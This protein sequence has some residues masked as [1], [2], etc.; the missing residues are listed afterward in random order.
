MVW[1]F[2]RRCICAAALVGSVYIP[3]GKDHFEKNKNTKSELFFFSFALNAWI[4][5]NIP[6]AK[7]IRVNLICK[8][9]L[10]T[11]GLLM[12]VPPD[13]QN[14]RD[15][16]RKTI[17]VRVVHMKWDTNH[18]FL[19]VLDLDDQMFPVMVCLFVTFA[20]LTGLRWN[21]PLHERTPDTRQGLWKAFQCQWPKESN[22]II[23]SIN[24]PRRVCVLL[25]L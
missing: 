14:C 25:N 20:G 13:K 19:A 1:H 9:L 7:V 5:Q 23:V 21:L 6:V 10:S 3:L 2:S 15:P 4:I 18:V 11:T 12:F 24:R 8:Y 16:L 17:Y 22:A